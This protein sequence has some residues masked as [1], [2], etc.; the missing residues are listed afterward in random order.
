MS[1]PKHL[2]LEVPIIAKNSLLSKQKPAC[3][4]PVSLIAVISP[5]LSANPFAQ[6]SANQVLIQVREL[7]SCVLDVCTFNRIGCTVTVSG[8]ETAS[9]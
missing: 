5:S 6:T 1:L 8:W 3:Q 4:V 9:R 2:C 7:S